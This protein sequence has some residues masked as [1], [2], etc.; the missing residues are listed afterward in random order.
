MVLSRT[1]RL[2][3]TPLRSLSPLR[4]SRFFSNSRPRFIIDMGTVDTT[5]RLSRLRQLM[6]EHKVDVYSMLLHSP[7]ESG[8]VYILPRIRL[9]A[10]LKSFPQKIATS[11]STLR[12]ATAAEVSDHR[13]SRSSQSVDSLF[14]QLQNLFPV[15]L[16]PPVLRLSP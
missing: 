2:P 9:I 5:D 7:S 13:L 1:I 4:P 8:S 12:P 10:F 16:A 11:P 3:R 14:L 6:K 15:S